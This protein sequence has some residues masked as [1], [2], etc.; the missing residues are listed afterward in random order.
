M[1]FR[2]ARI[3]HNVAKQARIEKQLEDPNTGQYAFTGLRQDLARVR[4]RLNRLGADA[5]GV[6]ERPGSGGRR[7]PKLAATG[8]VLAA[9]AVFAISV[10]VQKA[11]Q[12]ETIIRENATP[13]RVQQETNAAEKYRQLKTSPQ[14]LETQ[15]RL[16]SG[17]GG[18]D[19][20]TLAAYMELNG[21]HKVLRG[22][23]DRHFQSKGLTLPHD[24][25]FT[26]ARNIALYGTGAYYSN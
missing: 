22:E 20:M 8:A 21:L 19:Y 11:P 14:Y 15:I 5:N 9:A 13:T 6:R 7:Y 23:A 2:N 4:S 16:Q 12:H 1:L 24:G 26:N 18:Y 25:E 10:F 17:N 3:N